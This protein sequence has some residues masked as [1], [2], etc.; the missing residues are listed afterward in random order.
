AFMHTDQYK[1]LEQLT[2]E[3]LMLILIKNP[4][5]EEIQLVM[6]FWNRQYSD[7][8]KETAMVLIEGKSAMT[9]EQITDCVTRAKEFYTHRSEIDQWWNEFQQVIRLVAELEGEKAGPWLLQV[10]TEDPV[11]APTANMA[12]KYLLSF[13][14]EEKIISI[15]RTKLENLLN[16]SGEKVY[17]LKTLNI[18]KKKLSLYRRIYTCHFQSLNSLNLNFA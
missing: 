17:F 13:H 15:L 7:M 5:P 16:K 8:F 14:Q 12:M 18:V 1:S 6:Q 4:N 3:Y 10:V 2:R 11:F 9:P